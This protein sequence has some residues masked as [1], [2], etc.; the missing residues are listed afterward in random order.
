MPYTPSHVLHKDRRVGGKAER[1]TIDGLHILCKRGQ[2]ETLIDL[3]VKM[4]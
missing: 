1:N 3:F 4:I 2:P